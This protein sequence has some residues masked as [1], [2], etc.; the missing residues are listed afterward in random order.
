VVIQDIV[1]VLKSAA[2][3]EPKEVPLFLMGHSIRGAEVLTLAY[4]NNPSHISLLSSTV[5][6]IL[7]DSPHIA[8]SPE[9]ENPKIKIILG[10]LAARLLPRFQLR[11]KMPAS[12]ITRDPAV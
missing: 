6:G 1:E 9:Q 4:S 12:T 2:A 3:E 11:H 5:Q 7:L 10:H 8:L